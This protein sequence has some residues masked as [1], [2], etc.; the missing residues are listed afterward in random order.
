MCPGETLTYDCTAYG[1]AT[2]STVWSGT[3]FDCPSSKNRSILLHSRFAG[4][5]TR[6]CNNGGIVARSIGVGNYS[7]TSELT[8][9]V[10]AEILGKTI[11]C[12]YDNPPISEIYLS[13][14]IPGG[15]LNLI[16]LTII[17]FFYIMHRSIFTT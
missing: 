9:T 17:N 7:Y 8:V 14:S 12:I 6:A 10:T 2:G 1:T 4:G 11:M 16:N 5:T 3:A 15:S 13:A